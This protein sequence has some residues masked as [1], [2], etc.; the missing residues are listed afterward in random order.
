VLLVLDDK[1]LMKTATGGDLHENKIIERLISNLNLA[2]MAP[3][4]DVMR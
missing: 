2:L 1:I 3:W 4:I